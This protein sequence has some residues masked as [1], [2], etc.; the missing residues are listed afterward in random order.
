M[1]KI[2]KNHCTLL[3]LESGGKYEMLHPLFLATIVRTLD[4]EDAGFGFCFM[5]E[6][7][8]LVLVIL[9]LLFSQFHFSCVKVRMRKKRR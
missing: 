3:V 1:G 2:D 5:Q 6:R 4:D 9:A 8:S 7:V